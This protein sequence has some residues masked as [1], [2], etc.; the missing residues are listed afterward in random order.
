MQLVYVFIEQDPRRVE[1][2]KSELA[3]LTWPPNVSVSVIEGSFDVETQRLLNGMPAYSVL[4]PTF[5]FI[6][7]FGYTEHDLQLSSR[8]LGFPRC[9]VLRIHAVS[10]HRP[11][12][13]SARDS[14]GPHE[15]LRERFVAGG[16]G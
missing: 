12:R 13:G 15:T 2:L 4:A 5:A 8:I 7:P 1:H 14:S 11:I 10:I 3:A 16:P 9:E 6:D